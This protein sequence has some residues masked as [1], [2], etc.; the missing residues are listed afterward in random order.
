MRP[1]ARD[2]PRLGRG[3]DLGGA[4]LREGAI[5]ME[6]VAQP[7]VTLTD[8]LRRTD[9]QLPVTFDAT[10]AAS[11]QTHDPVL[12]LKRL[13]EERQ[14]ESVEILRSWMEDEGETA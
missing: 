1:P 5:D 13:I 14:S 9:R 4:A 6:D 10:A 11:G 12:R 8:E 7:P 3:G 2:L